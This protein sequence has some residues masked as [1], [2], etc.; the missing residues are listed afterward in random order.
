MSISEDI[1]T[2]CVMTQPSENIPLHKK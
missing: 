1:A 2:R